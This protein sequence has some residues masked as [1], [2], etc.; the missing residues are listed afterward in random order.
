MAA[1]AAGIAAGAAYIGCFFCC[2]GIQECM[3]RRKLGKLDIFYNLQNLDDEHM[4]DIFLQQMTFLLLR[5]FCIL[6][7]RL[8]ICHDNN[9]PILLIEEKRHIPYC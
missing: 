1:F 5:L 2:K 6:M 9:M 3:E 4:N 7:W 8:D